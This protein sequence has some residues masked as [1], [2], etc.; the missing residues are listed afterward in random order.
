MPVTRR[1]LTALLVISQQCA[2]A[3][4][5][6]DA[7]RLANRGFEVWLGEGPGTKDG[8]YQAPAVWARRGSYQLQII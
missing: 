8:G 7:R 1:P 6:A 3:A 2:S 4:R 5:P